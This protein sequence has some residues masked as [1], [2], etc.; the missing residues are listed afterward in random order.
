MPFSFNNTPLWITEY[1]FND[2]ELAPTQEFYRISQDYFDELEEVERYSYFGSFR[3]TVSNVGPNAAMLTGDGELTAIGNMYLGF[4][5]T[6][7]E[8][9]TA[10]AAKRL[11]SPVLVALGVFAGAT[12]VV[13][14]AW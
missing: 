6:G 5:T 1:G 11:S 7:A 2:Q 4:G 10:S 13:L 8:P 9:T 14:G 3:S 12:A